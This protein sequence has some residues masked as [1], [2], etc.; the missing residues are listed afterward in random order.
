MEKKWYTINI[1]YQYITRAI[2]KL[3][4]TNL[5]EVIYANSINNF[6]LDIEIVL[7]RLKLKTQSQYYYNFKR[8]ITS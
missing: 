7:I 8:G 3:K 4:R 1:L 6:Y 2:K 5:T